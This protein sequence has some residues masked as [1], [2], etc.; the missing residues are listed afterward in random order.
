MLCCKGTIVLL[1]LTLVFSTASVRAVDDLDGEGYMEM[2]D[3]IAISDDKA[4]IRSG[5]GKQYKILVTVK[6]KECFDTIGT[7]GKWIKVRLS[8]SSYKSA[9]DIGWVASWLTEPV[10]PV[11]ETAPCFWGE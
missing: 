10:P 11:S 4:H 7:S 9:G 1:L 3:V 8:N 6:R 5:P 2:E